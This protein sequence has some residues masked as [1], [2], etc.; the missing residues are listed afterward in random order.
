M[1]GDVNAENAIRES[2]RGVLDTASLP[3]LSEKQYA[4]VLERAQGQP[5]VEAYK[6]AYNVSADDRASISGSAYNVES[7]PKVSK[8]IEACRKA[9]LFSC[10]VDAEDHARQLV[11]LRDAAAEKGQYSAAIRAE[12][13]RGQIA[14]LYVERHE[15]K[16][17]HDIG[18]KLA[19]ARQRV[20]QLRNNGKSAIEENK[21]NRLAEKEQAG[22][23]IVDAEVV[24]D[25]SLI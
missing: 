18:D 25:D 12:M 6:I 16:H 2:L 7:S 13:A 21:E 11:R 20:Q 14:G 1:P 8:W 17:E 10:T 9:A 15:H 4:Y 24:E 5:P 3:A 22:Y 23:E 19:A